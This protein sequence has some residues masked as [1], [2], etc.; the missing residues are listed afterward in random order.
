M[1][2][3][4]DGG[5]RHLGGA[6]TAG[7]SRGRSSD[8][9]RMGEG[10]DDIA[11]QGG[12]TSRDSQGRETG[13][14]RPDPRGVGRPPRGKDADGVGRTRDFGL[15]NDRKIQPGAEIEGISGSQMSP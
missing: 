5:A 11:S 13:W 2:R 8:G 14:S 15:P 6:A 1:T 4:T 9:K 3:I 10:Q 7:S 12:A